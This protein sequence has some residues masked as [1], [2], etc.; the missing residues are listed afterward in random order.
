[1]SE[2]YIFTV[3]FKFFWQL[4]GHREAQQH[5][6]VLAAGGAGGRPGPREEDQREPPHRPQAGGGSTRCSSRGFS[7]EPVSGP[8]GIFVRPMTTF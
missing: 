2:I 1:L 5:G 8:S 4:P 6:V 3:Y 7:R